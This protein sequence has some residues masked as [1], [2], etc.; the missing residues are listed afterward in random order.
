MVREEHYV[1]MHIVESHCLYQKL[2]NSQALW[3]TSNHFTSCIALLQCYFDVFF[4][5]FKASAEA[6]NKRQISFSLDPRINGKKD[7]RLIKKF[8]ARI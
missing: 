7:I 5:V 3:Q 4:S 1:R 6:K 8:L 2:N